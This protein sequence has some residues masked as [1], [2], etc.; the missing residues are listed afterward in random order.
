M[1]L[2]KTLIA[3]VICLCWLDLTAFADTG[4]DKSPVTSQDDEN[5]TLVRL[6]HELDALA[7]LVSE[8]ENKALVD[9]RV[10]LNYG[11]LRRDLELVRSG[12]EWHL[13]TPSTEPRSFEPL[14]GD[15]RY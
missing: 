2:K 4:T 13:N 10:R 9:T 7:P 8:A 15:Y 3:A 5:A 1:N 14:K 12:I 6:I 11:W